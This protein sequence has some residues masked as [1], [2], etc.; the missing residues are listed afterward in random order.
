MFGDW[1]WISERTEEQET[2]F[3][4]W[5][6]DVSGKTLTIVEVGA[7]EYVPTVRRLSEQTLGRYV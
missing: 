3:R 1:D 6:R 4:E 2:R 5:T 7:G